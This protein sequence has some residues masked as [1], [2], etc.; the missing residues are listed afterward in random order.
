MLLGEIILLVWQ[1][2]KFDVIPDFLQ[3]FSLRFQ[4]QVKGCSFKAEQ[5]EPSQVVAI[6][7]ISI[8]DLCILEQRYTFS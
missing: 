7:C 4:F 3:N 8:S 1:S 6:Y 5:Q 2:V